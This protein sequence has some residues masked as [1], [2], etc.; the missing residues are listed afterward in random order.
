[1]AHDPLL[2]VL[3]HIQ[4][5]LDGDLSL[6]T[7]ARMAGL[8][9]SHMHRTFST[10]LGETPKAYV[11]RLRLERAALS[12]WLRDATVG[13]V[14]AEVGFGRH[15]TFTRAFRRRFGVS[16]T[17]LR[18]RGLAVLPSFEPGRGAGEA[19][20]GEGAYHLSPTR[21]VTLGDKHLAFIR[22]VGPYESVPESLFDELV[23]WGVA[24]GL[25]RHR[26]LLGIGLDAPGITAP[27]KLRFDAALM[28][29]TPILGSGRVGYQL[30]KGRRYAFTT[31][32][33]PYST[34][35]AAYGEIIGRIGAMP[36]VSF[37]GL[38]VVEMYHET[39]VDTA[40][41]FNHT[42]LYLPLDPGES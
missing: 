25:G 16:P 33:G 11:S 7:L 23:E 28:L 18:T 36:G 13:A 2:P 41:E 22:H 26:P 31:H 12:L 40:L 8:S 32:V 17:Q 20:G 39:R 1:M 3:V 35:M 5:H 29:E 30:L 4:S 6:G 9:T 24:Q 14:A 21:V 19:Q 37:T 10:R 34:L 38:P 27:E 15:E 42:D